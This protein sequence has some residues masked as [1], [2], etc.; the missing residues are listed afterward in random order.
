[1]APV[2]TTPHAGSSSGTSADSIVPVVAEPP[3]HPARHADHGHGGTVVDQPSPIP[4]TGR[5]SVRFPV[6]PW[7]AALPKAKTPPSEATR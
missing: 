5:L 4:M 7:N 3:D 2:R 1:M 6:E